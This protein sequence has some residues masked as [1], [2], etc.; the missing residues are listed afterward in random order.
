MGRNIWHFTVIGCPNLIR[1]PSGTS[2]PV[3]KVP[4]EQ[5]CMSVMTVVICILSTAAEATA[6]VPTVSRVKRTNGW[7]SR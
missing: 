4:L 1:K 7:I 2:L 6:I 3:E 5:W